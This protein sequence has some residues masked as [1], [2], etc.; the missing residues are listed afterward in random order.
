M[1]LTVELAKAFVNGRQA[2]KDAIVNRCPIPMFVTDAE[3]RWKCVNA[4]HAQLLRVPESD[5]C[6]DGWRKFMDADVLNRY[7]RAVSEKS[8]MH[9]VA[10]T[11]HPSGSGTMHGFMDMAFISPDGYIGWFVPICVNPQ[12]CPTHILLGNIARKKPI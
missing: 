3:G 5:L 4:L 2:L 11:V 1:S 9:H 6:G 7:D 8:D 10:C 12:D